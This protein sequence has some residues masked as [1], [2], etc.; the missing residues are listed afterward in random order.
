MCCSYMLH[1]CGCVFC[2]FLF[3]LYFCVCI[4]LQIQGPL[5][6]CSSIRQGVS[7]L[8]YC[9]APLVCVPDVIGLLAVWW[10]NKPKTKTKTKVTSLGRLGT[11]EA[12]SR[13]DH[14]WGGRNGFLAEVLL[15]YDLVVAHETR[16]Q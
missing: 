2:L 3:C 5:R 11:H 14:E 4:Y 12:V 8:H 15:V 7:R 9:C 13:K 1:V 16:C 10:H 6:E